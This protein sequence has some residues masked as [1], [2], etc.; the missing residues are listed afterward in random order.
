MINILLDGY[1]IDAVWLCDK[2]KQYIKPS[3]SVT[4]VALSFRDAHVKSVSD[5]DLLYS[6][7]KEILYD[8][9]TRGFRSYKISDKNIQF[10]NYYTDTKESASQKIQN[11][12]I[13]YLPGGLPDRMMERIEDLS[14]FSPLKKHKGIVMGYSAGALV[15]LSEYHLSPDKDY[16]EFKYCRGLSYLNDFYLEVHYNGTREQE[17]AIHRVISERK[18]VLYAIRCCAGALIIN[19][20]EVDL[21]GEVEVFK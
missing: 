17:N 18:K 1:N 5:W 9:I 8:R 15:Q 14:L 20:G 7:E 21:I 6:K 10:I 3:Y 12:D 2:L 19:N 11:A 16:S 4:V 13:I